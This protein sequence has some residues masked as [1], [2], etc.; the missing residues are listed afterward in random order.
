MSGVGTR[1]SGLLL[2]CVVVATA[3]VGA[4]TCNVCVLVLVVLLLRLL[5][6][7]LLIHIR[8]RMLASAGP[9]GQRETDAVDKL[10][11]VRY[12]N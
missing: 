7:M 5:L 2:V 1:R 12:L 8:R 4:I 10:L 6:L 9:S 3:V 11:S